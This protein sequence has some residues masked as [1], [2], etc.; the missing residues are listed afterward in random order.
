MIDHALPFV[1]VIVPC[2]DEEFT[3]E[4]AL[5]GIF[6]SDYPEHLLE[7]IVVHGQSR[8]ETARVLATIRAR[9]PDLVVIENETGTTPSNLNRG[10]RAAHGAVV[11][12]VD[13]HT[14]IPPR[15]VRTMVDALMRTGAANVGPWLRV[16]PADDSTTSKAIAAVLT[17]PLGYGGA[18]YRHETDVDLS[19]DTVPFGCFRRSLF[20]EI[21][22]F[23][24]ELL[25]N[26]DDEL[27]HRILANGGRILLIPVPV[28]YIARSSLKDLWRM[29]FQYGLFK[30][31][32]VRKLGRLLTLRQLAPPLLVAGLGVGL[33]AFSVPT[34]RWV[35]A[36]AWL[37][38]AVVLTAGSLDVARRR[39]VR[40]G[41]LAFL[42]FAA[43]HL[44]YGLGYWRG[45]ARIFGR[46]PATMPP[47]RSAG[48]SPTD[49]GR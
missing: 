8:D 45:L 48:G 32:A 30:P 46:G 14:R 11:I 33:L 34:F 47:S 19:V 44:A 35:G 4:S 49:S 23:D 37:G 6:A 9:H 3:I 5:E 10:L 7:I 26:Q 38:Y 28:D 15:Y 25:R 21:G 40:V 12:R 13:A 41:A 24:E 1:S 17:H 22:F 29:Y 43:M 31:L 39:G 18:A 16:V 36:A 20:D 27:N 42:A 2:R